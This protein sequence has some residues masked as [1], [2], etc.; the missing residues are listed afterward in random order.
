MHDLLEPQRSDDH[1]VPFFH[2][3][4]HKGTCEW[5]Q[6][7]FNQPGEVST[8]EIYWFD[9]TGIRECRASQSWRVLYRMGNDWKPVHTIDIYGVEKDRYHQVIFETVRTVAIRL[10][11]QSQPG[12]AG[13]INEWRLR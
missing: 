11:I 4:P 13:G 8:V 5:V 2:L 6:Y 12:V 10:E 9:D 1:G 7:D 3:W